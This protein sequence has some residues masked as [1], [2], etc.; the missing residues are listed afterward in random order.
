MPQISSIDK[1]LHQIGLTLE[2]GIGAVLGIWS[3]T[4]G[5]DAVTQGKETRCDLS[6][7]MTHPQVNCTTEKS[8]QRGIF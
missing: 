7:P 4:G 6:I 1:L 3:G 2:I 8:P 5:V